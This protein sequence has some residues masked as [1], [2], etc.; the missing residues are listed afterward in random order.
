MSDKEYQ[1]TK[2]NKNGQ[3]SQQDQNHSKEDKRN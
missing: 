1:N 2:T 3:N